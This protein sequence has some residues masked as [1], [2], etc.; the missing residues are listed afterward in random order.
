M[1]KNKN[2]L[3][4]F[5]MAEFENKI[6]PKHG[7]WPKEKNAMLRRFNGAVDLLWSVEPEL[8]NLYIK[9][10]SSDSELGKFIRATEKA[11]S[12]EL[13]L[14]IENSN[15]VTNSEAELVSAL[16]VFLRM[17][18]AHYARERKVSKEE[19]ARALVTTAKMINNG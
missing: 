7:Q 4:K 12:K 16:F 17:A 10:F 9:N 15:L 18:A 3:L 5:A 8:L 19:L 13:G 11:Y 2:D 6:V 1:G 14:A